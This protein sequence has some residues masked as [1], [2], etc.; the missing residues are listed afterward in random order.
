MEEERGKKGKIANRKRERNG[1]AER[2][3][4]TDEGIGEKKRIK[5]G[6]R[7]GKCL[8]KRERKEMKEKIK[9]G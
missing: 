5:D 7:K 9:R 4:V 1:R 8:E 3:I 6:R 2:S